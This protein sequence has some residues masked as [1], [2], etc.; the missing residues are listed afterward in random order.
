MIRARESKSAPVGVVAKVLRIFEA[1]YNAP[2]GLHLKDLAEQTGMNKSTTYRMLAHLEREGYLFRDDTG[3][4]LIGPKLVR[5]GSAT[6]YQDT[7][8]RI[9]HPV[10]QKLWKATAET[11]NIGILDGREVLYL[12]V[13]VSPQSFR[14]VSQIG[15]RRPL[16][17]TA[18]GKALVAYL[19][20]EAKERLISSLKLERFTRRTLTRLA[21]LRKELREVRQR[22]YGLDDEETVMGAR[23]VGA[24]IF[25]Q[26]GKAV[27]AISL[28]GPNTRVS[29]EETPVF[30]AAVMEAARSISARLGYSLL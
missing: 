13:I 27:A 7:L 26:D 4:Y 12:D 16:H 30:A 29:K 6:T 2:A 22:G 28:S 5:M 14:L 1:L 9:S 3:A 21:Q 8:R 23:C 17:C 19:P 24:P 18:L 20:D 25:D 10:L 15:T 11:V